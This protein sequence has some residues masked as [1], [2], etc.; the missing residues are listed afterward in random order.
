[1]KRLLTF[2]VLAAIAVPAA[3]AASVSDADWPC[4]NRTPTAERYA[5]AGEIT[6]ANVARLRVTATYDAGVRTAFQSGVIAIG[7]TLYFTTEKGV[8]ALDGATGRELWRTVEDSLADSY[9][10]VNRGVA[11]LDGR[12]F[13]G[14]QDGRVFAYDAH[15]GRR[16]W[17]ARIA[18]PAKGE[19]VP[20]CPAAWNDRVFIGN[21]GG[22]N[23]GVQGRVYALDAATGRQLWETYLVPAPHPVP[24]ASVVSTAPA[25]AGSADPM[26][27][28]AARTWGN[29]GDAPITG[30]CTWTTYTLDP[31]RGLLYVPGGNPSPDFSRQTRPGK[32]LFTNSVVVLDARTGEYRA[33][34]S[35]VPEDFHDW[36]VAAAPA[37]FTARNG[38]HLLAVAPKDGHLYGFDLDEGDKRLYKVPTTTITNADKEL[39]EK[40][41]RFCPG[42]QGGSEWNGPAYCPLTDLVYTGAVDWCTTVQLDPGRVRSVSEGQPWTGEANARKPFGRQDTT[43]MWG[44]WLTAT[45]AANGERAWRYRTPAPILSGVTP[46]GGG[47]VFFGDMGGRVYALDAR[48]GRVLWTHDL[49]GAIG[50]GVI[51]YFADGHQRVA[52]CSG[53]TSPIWPTPDVTAK[54]TIFTVE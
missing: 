14:T 23:K 29:A 44:G 46:T 43:S 50:G 36:D 30:G 37:L 38:H 52:V 16:L 18:D 6:V 13:R 33:H 9:L 28:L 54:V 49:D 22:D 5:P 34:F 8:Y 32:N 10:K 20:A 19:S 17:Q 41:V 21:A 1:M 15:T 39:G 24:T 47:L 11:Y 7:G 4:Y 35:L 42:S 12:L 3:R 26:Q 27:E 31:A 25:R 2:V 51:T 45:R 48:N 40:P 53:M